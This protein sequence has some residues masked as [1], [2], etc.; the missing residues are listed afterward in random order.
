MLALLTVSRVLTTVDGAEKLLKL[1]SGIVLLCAVAQARR[2]MDPSRAFVE[3]ES[4]L[5]TATDTLAGLHIFARLRDLVYWKHMS[6]PR[7]SSRIWLTLANACE[8]WMM[9]HAWRWTDDRVKPQLLCNIR[10]LSTMCSCVASLHDLV[11]RHAPVVL[12]DGAVIRHSHKHQR[13]LRALAVTC[14]FFKMGLASA[15]FLPP[16]CIATYA[17]SVWIILSYT[18]GLWKLFIEHSQTVPIM[19]C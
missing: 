6:G 12:P 11:V 19:V 1:L 14:E 8:T 18:L 2:K 15:G 4:R 16:R 10:N 17:F 13:S 9:L 5:K 7:R 3:T